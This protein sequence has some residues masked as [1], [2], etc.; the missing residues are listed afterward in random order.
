LRGQVIAGFRQPSAGELEGRI[1]AQIVKI[2]RIRYLL[3]PA[4]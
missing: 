3:N 4:E 1:L 2:I